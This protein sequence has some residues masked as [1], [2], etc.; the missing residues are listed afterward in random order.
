MA[1]AFVLGWMLVRLLARLG[2]FLEIPLGIGIGVGL[3][4]AIFFVLTWIGMASRLSALV[5]EGVLIAAL[6]L[7]LFRARS[8]T[9]SAPKRAAPAWI[10]ALRIAAAIALCLTIADFSQSVSSNPDG[11]YDA[12]AIWN[13]RARY[14]AGG[15]P[16][17]HYAVSDKTGTNHP[18]YPLLV[19]A[20]VARTWT[21]VGDFRSSTPAALGGLFGLGTAALLAATIWKLAGEAMAWLAM[22]VLLATEGFVSLAPVQYADVPLSFYILAA[23]ALLAIAEGRGGIVVLAGFAGGMAAWTKNEGLV[24][25]ALAF[26]IALWRRSGKWFVLGAAPMVALTLVF[27]IAL[28]EGREAMFPATTSQALHMITDGSRWRE[29]FSS[30]GRNFWEMG[31]PWA[32]PLLLMA[33][34]AWAFGFVREGR[35]RWW[36]LI[37]PLGLLAADFGIYLISATG[38]TWHLSTSNNRV[39][40]QVWPALVMGYFWMLK[41]PVGSVAARKK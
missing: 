3:S 2:W 28:V 27:K 19:S 26:A 32:H 30:F 7:A 16:S 25:A 11:G 35:S 17:W 40:A 4:S 20:F 15:S 24:F 31:F 33:A 8:T 39:I 18:G 5:V 9:E 22:L 12:A 41:P 37:A 6:G 1:P 10:W 14:L 23:V 13:V 29:I 34:L 38:L 36:A 21:I